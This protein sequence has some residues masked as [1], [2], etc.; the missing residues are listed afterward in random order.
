MSRFFFILSLKEGAS[1]A[2]STLHFRDIHERT[3][4]DMGRGFPACGLGDALDSPTGE[5]F[6]PPVSPISR[7]QLWRF[8]RDDRNGERAVEGAL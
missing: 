5:S 4:P 7:W 2:C 3:D 8:Q 6:R 1:Q